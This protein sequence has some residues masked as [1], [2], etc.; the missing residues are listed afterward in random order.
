MEQQ[1]NLV[2]FATIGMIY[3]ILEGNFKNED[4]NRLK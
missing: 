4:I 3:A 2:L 1:K